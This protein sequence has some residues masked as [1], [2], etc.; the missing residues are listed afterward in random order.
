MNNRVIIETGDNSFTIFDPNFD[1]IFHSKKGAITE[2][3][4]VFINSGLKPKLEQSSNI[5]I[6]EVGFGTGLNTLLTLKESINSNINYYAIEAFPLTKDLWSKLDYDIYLPDDM[7]SYF[8]KLHEFD[9]NISN[10]VTDKFNLTKINSKLEDFKTDIK[11]DLIY[12]DAFSPEKQP[13]LWTKE[14]F[15][16]LSNMMSSSAILVTYCAKGQVRR[17]LIES[18]LK[19]EKLAGPPGKREMLRAIKEF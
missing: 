7:K 11:F 13:E 10:K 9:W 4:H 15:L 17:D 14:I 2:S 8:Y 6:L 5:N 12:F 18:G 19:V 1:E 16:K 3:I